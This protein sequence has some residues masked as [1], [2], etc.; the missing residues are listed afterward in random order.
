MNPTYS[1]YYVMLLHLTVV[2]LSLS[3]TLSGGRQFFLKL[4]YSGT[5]SSHA[6]L[7]RACWAKLN[8]IMCNTLYNDEPWN[9]G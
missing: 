6:V 8:G 2:S 3:L 4:R 1:Y 5:P 9:E 7:Q